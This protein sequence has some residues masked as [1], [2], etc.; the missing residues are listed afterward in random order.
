LLEPLDRADNAVDLA[1]DARIGDDRLLALVQRLDLRG[2]PLRVMAVA[3][4][5]LDLVQLKRLRAGVVEIGL[6][7]LLQRPIAGLLG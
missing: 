3:A 7:A 5:F 6:L 1:A 2:R 4:G